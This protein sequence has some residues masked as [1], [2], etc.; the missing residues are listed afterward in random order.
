[1]VKIKR[2]ITKSLYLWLKTFIIIFLIIIVLLVLLTNWMVKSFSNE[3]MKLNHSLTSTVQTSVDIRLDDIDHFTAQLELNHVNLTLAKSKSIQTMDRKSLYQL[4]SQLNDYKLSNAF[5]QDIYIYY[6]GIDY[7]VGD[8]GYFYSREY[9]LLHHNLD[10]DGYEEWLATI[11]SPKKKGYH[12]VNSSKDS[13]DLIFT[14]SLPYDAD[15]DKRAIMMIRINKEEVSRLLQND[16]SVLLNSLTAIVSEKND[17]Y[18]YFGNEGKLAILHEILQMKAEDSFV[19]IHNYFASVQASDSYN[20]K[21]ITINDQRQMLNT[22]YFIR[23]I[24]YLSIGLCMISG[25][26]LFIFMS[27]RNNRPMRTIIEKLKVGPNDE[28]R[29]LLDDYSLINSEIDNMLAASMK[30]QEKSEIQG[31]T[32]ESLF[33]YNLLS[34]EERNNSIIFASMQRFSLQFEFSSFQVLLFRS[35]K[36]FL[37]HE[38]KASIQNMIT[39]AKSENG[40]FY[41]IATEFREDIVLLL[42]MD[43]DYGIPRLQKA[44]LDLLTCVSAEQAR[45]LVRGGGIYDTMSNIITSYQQALMLAE[46]NEN[47]EDQI[48]FYNIDML[49]HNTVGIQCAEAMVEYEMSM[50]EGNYENAQKLID[51]LFNQYIQGEGN[52]FLLQTKKYAVL[53]LLIEAMSKDSH[54]EEANQEHYLL[55][56]SE[57]KNNQALL[58]LMHEIF[59][60]LVA[61][62]RKK[63]S[64]QEEGVAERARKYI[65]LNFSDSMI[66]LYSISDSLGISNA[67]LSTAFKKK[68]NEGISQYINKL[69]ISKAKKLILNTQYSMK[70]IA[71]SVGFA[72][73]VTFIRVFKQF[74]NTTPGKF[75]K[76]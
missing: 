15:E 3:V 49:H 25:C 40:D 56:L 68:Y 28:N 4:A 29:H 5:I 50:L 64:G 16:K 21:F 52:V 2:R 39:M 47:A 72:S 61:F 75:K 53:N 24:A 22:S 1:M 32:I 55:K 74:E 46:A 44:A 60:E 63:Q 70:E 45:V 31:K 51:I 71:L 66:G 7:V 42:H 62:Q 59:R 27:R 57:A 8:L 13:L 67:Y 14:R 26:I 38:I 11:K 6:P 65:D 76:S 12:F 23:N 48:L 34:N 58:K 69:R 36:G 18:T 54:L 41:V 10:Y 20:I 30:I 33:L 9:Y 19:K 43:A 35:N 37:S 17:I 73:D